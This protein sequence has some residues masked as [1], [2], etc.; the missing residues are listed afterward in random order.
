MRRDFA[1]ALP[2]SCRKLVAV[3]LQWMTRIR[4]ESTEKI[5]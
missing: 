5:S 3:S 2:E 4:D 1:T